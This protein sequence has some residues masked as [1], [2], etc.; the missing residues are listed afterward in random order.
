MFVIGT[1]GHIDHGKSALVLALTGIDPDRL[2]EEKKRG[3][4]I[5]LGFAWFS[6]PSGQV[7]GIVDVPG[8]KDFISNVI[9]GIGG[10]DATIIVIAAD[11][12][13]MPQTEE[14]LQILNLLGIEHGI[15]A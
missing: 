6:L 8:H 13:W 10:I 14:H 2:P 15:V 11:D 4:T 1:A 5:D 9:P 12:G 7:I 3:M